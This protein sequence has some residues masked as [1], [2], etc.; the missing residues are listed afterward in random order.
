MSNKEETDFDGTYRNLSVYY[1]ISII[2][3]KKV[4]H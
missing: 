2:E 1:I 4:Y 3:K